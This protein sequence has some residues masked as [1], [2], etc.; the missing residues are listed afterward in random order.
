MTV[1]RV[2][3]NVADRKAVSEGAALAVTTGEIVKPILK[4]V[5]GIAAVVACEGRIEKWA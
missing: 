1:L 3:I 2:P 5:I 4:R